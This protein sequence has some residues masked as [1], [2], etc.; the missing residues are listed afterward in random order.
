MDNRDG[1][2]H[3]GLCWARNCA[4]YP[5]APE[6]P[7]EKAEGELGFAIPTL[8]KECY[9][10]IGNGGFGPGLG[11]IGVEGGY[12]SDF[13]DLVR[14]YEFFRADEEKQARSWPTAVLPFC[15]WG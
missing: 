9:R 14:I 11:V 8:L 13:G 15:E 3:R 7:I 5:P 6:A 12:E 2:T 10:R 1:R 4:R